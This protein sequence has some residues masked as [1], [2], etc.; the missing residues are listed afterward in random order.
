MGLNPR[1]S[2]VFSQVLLR[3]PLPTVACA[4]SLILQDECQRHVHLTRSSTANTLLT[5]GSMRYIPP[6]M[7]SPLSAP[8]RK[9]TETTFAHLAKRGPPSRARESCAHCRI[10][11]H[12]YDVC[13]CLHG[14]PANY[15]GR[16]CDQPPTKPSNSKPATVIIQ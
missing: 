2:D 6:H 16:H 4:N 12:Y 11:G 7:D 14:L 9:H 10:P 3:N 8:S 5:C 15:K 13:F 1:Y